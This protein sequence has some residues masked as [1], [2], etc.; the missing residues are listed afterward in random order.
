MARLRR[1]V[2]EHASVTVPIALIVLTASGWAIY[3]Y[4][5][6][7]HQTDHAGACCPIASK[8]GPEG[9]M[10]SLLME[11]GLKTLALDAV[12]KKFPKEDLEFQSVN[13]VDAEKGLVEMIV[14]V[15]SKLKRLKVDLRY[16]DGKVIELPST[17][18]PHKSP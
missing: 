2:N 10:G 14:S 3:R 1:W 16:P 12:R 6:T 4:S 17:T 18:T 5:T 9:K 7:N 8:Y 13:V 11:A 15:S